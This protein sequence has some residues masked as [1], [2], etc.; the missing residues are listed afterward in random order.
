MMSAIEVATKDKLWVKS[1]KRDFME[2]MNFQFSVILWSAYYVRG[3][4]LSI[5]G[6]KLSETGP[7]P[8]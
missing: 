7:L 1:V 3:T 4:V 2:Q 6:I 5:D 8:L